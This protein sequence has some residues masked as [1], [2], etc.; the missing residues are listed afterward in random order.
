MI[1]G[2]GVPNRSETDEGFTLVEALVAVALLSLLSVLVAGALRF[3]VA[4]WQ[5]GGDASDRIDEIIHAENFLRGMIARASPHFIARPGEKGHVAFEG[6]ARSLRFITEAPLAFDQA[7][8]FVVILRA[9]TKEAGTALL[10]ESRPELAA[11]DGKPGQA[12]LRP[13]LEG[14]TGVT[15]AYFGAK[16]PRTAREWHRDWV[17]EAELPE[18]IRIDLSAMGAPL[19]EPIIIRPMLDVDVSCVFDALTKRCRGR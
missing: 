17:R 14:L 2:H 13:L 3:G 8:R 19:L 15:L 12:A 11:T 9:E 7:G 4:A 16:S 6:Q 1:G 10:I 5:R 18:L